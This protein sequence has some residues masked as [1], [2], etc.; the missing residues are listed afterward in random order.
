MQLPGVA[1]MCMKLGKYS[2]SIV[3]TV[4]S[5]PASGEHDQYTLV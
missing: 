4:A 3:L 5:G 2:T 1:I